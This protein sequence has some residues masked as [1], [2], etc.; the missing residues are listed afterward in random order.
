MAYGNYGYNM[1]NTFEGYVVK[2]LV[3]EQVK[4]DLRFTSD[5]IDSLTL[6]FNDSCLFNL[7]D[8]YYRRADV[9][10]GGMDMQI[11]LHIN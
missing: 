4:T 9:M 7:P 11:Y 3:T 8:Q 10:F 1:I 2:D 5:E 6:L